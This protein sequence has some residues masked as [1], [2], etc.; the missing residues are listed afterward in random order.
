MKRLL[1]LF[2]L[3]SFAACSGDNG[4]APTDDNGGGGGGGTVTKADSTWVEDMERFM[5]QMEQWAGESRDTIAVRALAYIR[6]MPSVERAGITDETTVW[7][8][9]ANGFD[10]IIPNNRD[11]STAADTLVDNVSTPSPKV[12]AAP[13]RI[14]VPAG[15]GMTRAF[16]VPSSGR[17]LPVS[18][19]FRAV[20]AIG[21]CHINPL[22]VIKRLLRNGHYVDANPPAPTVAGLMNVRGDGVFYINS[23]GGP[24]FDRNQVAYYAIWTL[25]PLVTATLGNYRAMVNSH[26]LV[27]MVEYSNDAQ[28][29]CNSVMHYGITSTFVRNRMSFAKNSIVIV[30]A[31]ASASAPAFALRDAFGAA[32]AS[33]YVGWTK[34][35]T[36]GFA[37]KA[38]KYLIDRML[39]VNEITP[40]DPKQRAFNIYQVRNDMEVR[41]QLVEEPA[42]HTILTVVPLKDDFGLLSPSIQFLSIEDD[43]VQ[44]RLIIAGLFGTDPGEGKRSVTINGTELGNVQWNPTEIHCD[45][46]ESGGNAYGTVVVKVG[47]GQGARASN[48]VNITQ[49]EGE[50]TYERDDPGDQT[51]TMSIKF[52]VLADIHDF[53]DEPG[54]PPF[55]TQVLFGPRGGDT[56][57][58]VTTGGK[59]EETIG[60]CTETWTFGQGGDLVTPFEGT[61]NGAWMYFG[62]VDT[63]SHT[64]QL[65]MAVLTVFVAGTWVATGPPGECETF[66]RPYY[67][68][69]AIDDCLYDDLVQTA[70]FRI[71]MDNDFAVLE[72]QR[73]P[74]TVDPLVSQLSNS[75]QG[76][77][78]IRWGTLTPLSLPDPDAAR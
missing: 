2:A 67:V 5:D 70:A 16:R 46:P 61:P 36:S 66:N 48:P 28:G 17:E 74:C 23:H 68:T 10:L 39:G 9:F 15:R 45:I 57:V 60:N 69:V 64:L 26:E 78:K 77:A 34:S 52:R 50:L 11:P 76:Q 19:Q 24:G 33:V 44:P 51:A 21:T 25:D 71:Q 8:N 56:S 30:D 14:V 12:S 38:M 32:G 63:E 29:N 4:T 3:L 13:R 73:G 7:A 75:H 59:Y 31:C 65:N 37:Y 35:V 20:N 40:E 22:P 6:G 58:H 72:D 18:N 47:S 41:R 1:A 42:N 27:G 43:G 54:E 49:W 53:R 55:K 62:S